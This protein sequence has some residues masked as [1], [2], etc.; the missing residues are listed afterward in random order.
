MRVDLMVIIKAGAAVMGIGFL[1]NLFFGGGV[2]KGRCF[3][4]V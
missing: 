3:L 1:A 2:K 4:A